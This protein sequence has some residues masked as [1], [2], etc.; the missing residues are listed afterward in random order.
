MKRSAASSRSWVVTPGRAFP[1][2]IARQRAST[3]PAAS[4]C[5][6]S[7]GDFLTIIGAKESLETSQQSDLLELVFE[8]QG[9]E[10]GPNVVV[11]LARRP[12]G[13]EAPEDPLAVV[14]LDE[15][16]RFAV[17]DLEPPLDRLRLVV[18]ALD[19]AGAVLVAHALALRRVELH[20]VEV[21]VLHAYAAA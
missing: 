14:V 12:G 6:I 13:V 2:S 9:G 1:R 3:C 19:Q 18:V 16:G 20:V 8:P 15:R 17:V 7:S 10:G 11:N 21:A 4:I 5:S